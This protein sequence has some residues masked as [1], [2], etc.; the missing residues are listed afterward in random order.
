MIL[1]M[2]WGTVLFF[3]TTAVP[4]LV[5][6]AIPLF[7]ENPPPSA[8]EW[9]NREIPIL[10][11]AFSFYCLAGDSWVS[12]GMYL[13]L[14]Y[15]RRTL[16]SG[17]A[18]PSPLYIHTKRILVGLLTFIWITTPFFLLPIIISMEKGA[19]TMT[20]AVVWFCVVMHMTFVLLYLEN[21]RLLMDAIASHGSII[22]PPSALSAPVMS[23]MAD[24]DTSF[25]KC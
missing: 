20:R 12:I 10:Y 9:P 24:S 22:K 11:A 5:L 16:S 2:R 13:R 17:T 21:V 25:Y 23:K 14:D 15:L 19:E 6:K 3:C 4:A 8:Y 1:L 7:M 18:A